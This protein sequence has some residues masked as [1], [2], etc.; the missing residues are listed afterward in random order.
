[1]NVGSSS[2]EPTTK[3]LGLKQR[4]ASINHKTKVNTQPE[5]RA[6]IEG[7]T[8]PAE[9]SCR[10]SLKNSYNALRK[11]WKSLQIWKKN[12]ILFLLFIA[13]AA[14]IIA[15]NFLPLI[16][17]HQQTSTTTHSTN[18]T[19]EIISTPSQT[20]KGKNI[21]YDYDEE[22]LQKYPFQAF[23][24]MSAGGVI[25]SQCFA[26]FVDCKYKFLF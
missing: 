23:L 6:N 2:R 18:H 11:W 22:F 8:P 20:I 9:P 15:I 13:I 21:P 1:M 17:D 16:K 26:T 3:S 10:L 14:P 5:S 25:Q 24:V 4:K 7:Q 12:L 19:T